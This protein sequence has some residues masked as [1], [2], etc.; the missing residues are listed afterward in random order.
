MINCPSFNP[1]EDPKIDEEATLID[2]CR[3]STGLA[4]PNVVFIGPEGTF[5]N[6]EEDHIAA[7]N[8]LPT[9]NKVRKRF[10][11]WWYY[12]NATFGVL[13]PVVEAVSG[14]KFSEFF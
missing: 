6:T 10:R 1:I 8:A 12:S 4:N 7:L 11:S 9:S 13:G 2:A 3:H 5:S 14:I